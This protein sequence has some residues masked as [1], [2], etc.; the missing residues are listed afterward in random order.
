MVSKLELLPDTGKVSVACKLPNGLRLDLPVDMANVL[1]R[2]EA[3]AD[4][5]RNGRHV[6]AGVVGEQTFAVLRGFSTHYGMPA[7]H[8]SGGYGI[9]TGVDAAKFK[10]WFNMMY[11]AKY[12]PVLNGLVFACA[13][14]NVT[15]DRA[16][17]QVELKSGLEPIDPS[18]PGHGVEAETK[19]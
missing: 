11:K 1:A 5:A 4:A 18:N 2:E 13:S 7:L 10:A 16:E 8:V 3:H 17:E 12:A 9:T 6:P 15:R 19:E 14:E